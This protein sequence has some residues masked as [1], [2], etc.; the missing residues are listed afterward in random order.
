MALLSGTSRETP[1]LKEGQGELEEGD[2]K[3]GER[4]TGCVCGEWDPTA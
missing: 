4:E 1:L 2:E 3:K